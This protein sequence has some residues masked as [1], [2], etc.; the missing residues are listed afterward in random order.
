MHMYMFII[1]SYMINMQLCIQEEALVDSVDVAS[2]D[3][4][5]GTE[6]NT[7]LI[8]AAG[9]GDVGRLRLLLDAGY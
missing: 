5:A 9:Y 8:R 6:G 3:E 1:H 7:A 4:R 2:L